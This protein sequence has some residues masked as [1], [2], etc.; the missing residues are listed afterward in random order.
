MIE[1]HVNTET[2]AANTGPAQGLAVMITLLRVEVDT[3]PHP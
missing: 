1:A 3:Y 2:E